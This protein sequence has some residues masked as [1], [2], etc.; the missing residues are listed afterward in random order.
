MV[1]TMT[2]FNRA[3]KLS[4]VPRIWDLISRFDK[5]EDI[6]A[7]EIHDMIKCSRHCPNISSGG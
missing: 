2:V 4:V 5:I 1:W 7:A 6:S 3:L